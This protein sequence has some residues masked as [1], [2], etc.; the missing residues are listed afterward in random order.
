MLRHKADVRTIA[1]MATYFSL[2]AVQFAVP[3]WTV[4]GR[5][6]AFGVP[7]LILTCFFSFFCAVATHNTVHC[8]VFRSRTANRVFQAALTVTYGHPVSAFVPGHN[9]SHHKHTQTRR[10]VMRTSKARFRWHLLNGLLFLLIV[11]PAVMR[12]EAAYFKSMRKRAPAW[13]RQLRIEQGTLFG[14]YAVLLGLDI[15]HPAIF[16]GLKFLVFVFIPHK[17]AAWGIITINLIQHDGADPDSEINHSRNFVG[18]LANWFTF[19]NGFHTIHHMRPGL[20]WSLLPA[21]HAREVAPFI[22]PELDQKSLLLYLFRTFGNPG[23]RLRYDGTPLVLPPK[24]P[25]ETWV[26]RPEETGQ[27]LGAVTAT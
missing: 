13:F 24:E 15:W 25:D 14:L 5:N 2:V 10:D 17:Y 22:A 6:F 7:L 1:F 27:D 11:A 19:N 8:P 4:L 21:A 23:K 26:P 18:R 3:S 20:H 9:L 12:G 16:P